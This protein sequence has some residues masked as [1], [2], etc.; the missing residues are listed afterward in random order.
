MRERTWLWAG[1]VLSIGGCQG[2][3]PLAGSTVPPEIVDPTPTPFPEQPSTDVFLDPRVMERP[4]SLEVD[5]PPPITGGTLFVPSRGDVAV[6]ADPDRN[7]I[8]VVDLVARSV[9]GETN[10]LPPGSEPFRAAEDGDGRVHVVL[11]GTGDVYSFDVDAVADGVRH[12]VCAMPRGIAFDPDAG[13]LVVACRSGSLV[14]LG[15]DGSVRSTVEVTPDLRDVVVVNGRLF[16]S[17]FRAAELLELDR[18]SGAVLATQRPGVSISPVL[19]RDEQGGITQATLSPS[20]AWRTIGLPSGAQPI[21]AVHQRASDG[22]V[23]TEPGGYGASGSRCGGG[24]IVESVV[25][26]Y[27]ADGIPR[28]GASIPSATLAVDVAVSP[29]GQEVTIVAAGNESGEQAVQTYPFSVLALGDDSGCVFGSGP[30]NAD[31]SPA[32][33]PNAVAAAYDGAGR[34]LVQQRDP[35]ALYY[36]GQPIS[37]GGA[38]RFDTGHAV[39]HANSGSFIACASCHPE[40]GDDG[41]VW[42]FEGIGPRRTPAMHGSL[43]GTEPFHWDGDMTDLGVLVRQVFSSRMNGP[44]LTTTQVDHLGRWLDHGIAPPA[45]EATLDGDA[46]ARGRAIF[47]GEAQCAGCHAGP[48]LTNNT[49]VDVGT[50]GPFQVP[51]LVGVAYRLPLMHDGLCP[52]LRARLTDAACGGGE[53]HGHTAHLSAAQIDDLVAYLETL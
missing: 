6:V 25:T 5:P 31:G 35:A 46:A 45:H 50:G 11:R 32:R 8:V 9:M 22:A 2:P 20:V 51:S 29:D 23:A 14:T 10:D 27:D 13:S 53:Q 17:T 52:T 39:F 12:H 48:D 16:V 47:E 18:T 19:V 44:A 40:G 7:R 37:L 49:T 28:P 15:T 41:R 34:L 3:A 42:N 30:T 43:R 21:V 26:L 24:S 33:I 38:E 36:Q 4:T 1:L